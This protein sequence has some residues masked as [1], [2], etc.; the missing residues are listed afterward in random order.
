[1][2]VS[3]EQNTTLSL[4]VSGSLAQ[5]C[6]QRVKYEGEVCSKE[7]AQWQLC[8]FG[9]QNTSEI[10]LPALSDQ[11]EIEASASQLLSF[12]VSVLDPSS[13]CVAAFQSYL[14]LHLFGLCDANGQFCQVT[15]ADYVRLTKDVCETEF[16]N[17]VR[18]FLREAV[19][20]C[21]NSFQDHKIQC[22]GKYYITV[23]MYTI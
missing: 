15:R 9:P 22:L 3:E 13:E 10:Y 6:S 2:S 23:Y 12:F 16:N 11:Q 7:L 21:C 14:C 17:L 20:P 8:F 19:L 18:N 5:E 4:N 1:M